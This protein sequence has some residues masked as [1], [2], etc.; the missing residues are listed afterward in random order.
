MIRPPPRS[1]R[2]DT[3][4]PYTTLFRSGRAARIGIAALAFQPDEA[5]G[6]GMGV[7]DI[8]AQGLQ[9]VKLAGNRRGDGRLFRIVAFG[10]VLGRPRRVAGDDGF[11]AEVPGGAAGAAASGAVAGPRPEERRVGTGCVS[12]G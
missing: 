8:G 4:F 3:L 11:E 2:T 7:L 5:R 6:V 1:T 10:D 9:P 12:T